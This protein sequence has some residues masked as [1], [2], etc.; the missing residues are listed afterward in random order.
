MAKD[1]KIKVTY[2]DHSGFAVVTPTAILVF[3]YYRDPTEAL[4]KT[5]RE[6][7]SLPVVFFASHHHRDHFNPAIFHLAQ[8]NQRLYVLGDDIDSK[9]VPDDLAVQYMHCGDKIEGA[10]GGITVKAYD[11]TDKGVSFLVT[12]PDGETIF[13]AGDL[14]YWH[15]NKEATV[16]EVKK[17]Y[18]SFVKVMQSL[19]RDNKH[20][21]IAFFPVDPRLG[22]DYADGARLFLENILVDNFFP[23]HFWGDY[24]SGCDFEDYT[25]DN[26]DCFCLHQPGESVSLDGK[27][28]HREC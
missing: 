12:L 7:P 4:V 28:A 3:D 6:N 9:I 23:M 1:N 26:T 13:H 5:V 2:L 10:L 24:R 8:Q 18:N 21:D 16:D 27:M 25:T 17:A 14:N 20:F 15:W 19:M 22:E 11:S